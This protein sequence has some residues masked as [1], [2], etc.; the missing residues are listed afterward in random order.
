MAGANTYIPAHFPIEYDSNWS[1]LTQE[2]LNRLKQYVQV[3]TVQGQEKQFNQIGQKDWQPIT[4]RGSDTVITDT[5]TGKRL[6]RATPFDT[7]DTFD[8]WDSEFLGNIVLPTSDVMTV[9]TAG[10]NRLLDQIIVQ[11]A[12]GTAVTIT[13]PLTNALNT[14]NYVS[15]VLPTSGGP[16]GTGQLIAVDFNETASPANSS[17]T[18][19]KLRQAKFYFDY[20]DVEENEERVIALTAKELN[21]LLRDTQIGSRDWNDINAW[22]NGELKKFMG[23]TLKRISTTINP[24]ASNGAAA[25]TRICP[26]WVKSGIKIA[27]SG[28]K[29]YMDV[30]PMKR[31]SLQMRSTAA[32]GGTRME[33]KKVVGIVCA[34]NLA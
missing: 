14:N 33:E 26:A 15:T 17:M 20:N 10:Y 28:R 3:E 5:P 18:L 32:I 13:T 21:S 34:T 2:L 19:A 27:D 24:V 6:L 11:S 25:N 9:H 31:H 22:N 16:N 12:L 8:E 23:F 7:A 29:A 4:S 30:L 1:I